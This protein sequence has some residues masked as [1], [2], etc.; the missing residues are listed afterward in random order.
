M[1]INITNHLAVG[2]GGRLEERESAFGRADRELL[3]RWGGRPR[4][5][6]RTR[7]GGAWR[8]SPHR[9]R[10]AHGERRRTQSPRQGRAVAGRGLAG[11]GLP[12]WTEARS[13][14]LAAGS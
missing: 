9:F 14:G 4:G 8:S 12:A 11:G 1:G 7:E 10:V 2:R 13:L 6:R 5:S 3:N